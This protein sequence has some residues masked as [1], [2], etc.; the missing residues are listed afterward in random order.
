M[1][2]TLNIAN[3]VLIL[4]VGYLYLVYQLDFTVTI[5]A[6]ILAV[7]SWSYHGFSK[8]RKKFYEARNKLLEAKAAY[9]L[10]NKDSD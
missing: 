10:R 7:A 5:L 6:L 9:Y 8:E 2:E 1:G 3:V 4:G